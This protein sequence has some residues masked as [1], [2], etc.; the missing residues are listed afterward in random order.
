MQ[1]KIVIVGSLNMD[2]V[3]RAERL[4]RPGETLAGNSFTT[5]AGG[6][7]ANQAVAA[8]RLGA[9]VAMVGC[10]GADAYGESLRSGLLAEGIDCQA[11]TTLE[12]VSTGIASIVVDANSQ[13]AIMIV[14]GA[15]GGLTP[16]HIERCDAL[17]HAAD[18]VI[19]QLEVPTPTVLHTLKRARELGKTVI[20]NPAP[21][22][23]PLPA[24]WFPL[25]DYLIPNESEACALTGIT[26]DSPAAAEQAAGQLL[27]AGVRNVIVTLGERGVVR[28]T[29]ESCEH[30]AA[31]AVQALDTTAAGD[32][33]VGGFAAAL[34]GG[35]SESAAI[36]FG[37]KAAALSVT[38]P[39]AQPSIPTFAEVEEFKSA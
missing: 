1:A 13:N 14:A 21:A 7:G 3:I 27:A 39:G 12:Q 18:I 37:Q 16:A 4:P 2:L 10:V 23:G 11:V 38:R 25:I 19:C 15:N 36:R 5:V 32:T 26:V 29:L 20:L 33:F 24:E 9:A 17:L 22:V 35:Q 8:A 6:K 31:P 30:L 34:A 28:A